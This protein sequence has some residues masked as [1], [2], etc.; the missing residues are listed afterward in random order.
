MDR[1]GGL[2]CCAL[3]AAL[4]SLA[5]FGH[6]LPVSQIHRLEFADCDDIA[7]GPNEDVLLAGHSPEDRLPMTV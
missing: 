4:L 1:K 5:A 3:A 2:R 6:G 7:F